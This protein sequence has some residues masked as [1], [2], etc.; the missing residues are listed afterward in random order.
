MPK[1]KRKSKKERFEE[2]L[3]PN[4][5]LGYDWANIGIYLYNIR[6]FEIAEM[7]FRRANWLNPFEPK[8]KMLIARC[9][10][11]RGLMP[12]A[13]RWIK[14]AFEQKPKNEEIRRLFST[15]KERSNV[16]K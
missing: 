16:K 6:A 2:F 4:R 7:Q 13:F 15:I 12:E 3:R 1:D 8:F 9:L 11:K 10:Y 5:F 14:E